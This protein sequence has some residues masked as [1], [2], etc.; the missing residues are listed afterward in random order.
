MVKII[1][2]AL[3]V[4]YTASNTAKHPLYVS[5]TDAEY[6]S[7]E[8]SMEITSKIFLDDFE[9]TLKK[10]YSNSIDLFGN[11]TET[12][13]QYIYQYLKHHLSYTID[14]SASVYSII[15]YER[16]KDA[17]WVYLEING[18][19]TAPKSISISNSILHDFSEK[20]INIVHC[21]VSG[22]EKSHKFNYPSSSISFTY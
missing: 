8:K 4:Y 13:K 10:Q 3:V 14:G 22:T 21:T 9:A 11:A 20:Q 12:T 17:V 7:T 15:G 5:I 18:I 16:K 2:A 19:R 1:V 6:N